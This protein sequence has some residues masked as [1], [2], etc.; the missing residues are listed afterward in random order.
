[1]NELAIYLSYRDKQ[2]ALLRAKGLSEEEIA[3]ELYDR[4]VME[5]ETRA[6]CG[7]L[8]GKLRVYNPRNK[9]H[10]EMPW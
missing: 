8:E 9:R 10:E 7:S 2:V 1:M 6:D 5:E 3:D 4:R